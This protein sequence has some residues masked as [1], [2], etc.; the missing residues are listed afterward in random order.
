MSVLEYDDEAT[1]R[2]LAVYVTPDVTAQRNEFLHLFDP[3]PGERVLDVGAG[4]GFLATAIAEVVGE[5]GSVCGVDISESLL[6]VAR[7]LGKAQ[8]GIEFRHGDATRLPYSDEEFDAVVSTQVLEYVPDV[9]AALAEVHRVVRTGG[10]VALLDTDWDSIVW[11]S[12]D[13]ASMSRVLTAWEEHAADPFLPR[14]LARRLSCAGFQ[15]EVQ[16]IIPLLDTEFDPNTYSNRMIDLIIPFVIGRGGITRDDAEAWARDPRDC[17]T[18]GE[19]SFSL[20]R[21]LFLARRR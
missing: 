12:P 11:Y 8:H 20:N 19:Y 14:T 21:Y 6:E 10:R 7:S 9:H 16:K 18:N 4:P 13:R 2:L 3:H 15:V 1:Q 5:S 17:G